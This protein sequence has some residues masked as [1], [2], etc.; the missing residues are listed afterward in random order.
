MFGFLK[1]ELSPKPLDEVTGCHVSGWGVHINPSTCVRYH[2]D[3]AYQ[4]FLC[5]KL[6]LPWIEKLILRPNLWYQLPNLWW[7]LFMA[8]NLF[9]GIPSNVLLDGNQ[10]PDDDAAGHE[11]LLAAVVDVIHELGLDVLCGGR[12]SPVMIRSLPTTNVFYVMNILHAVY[13]PVPLPTQPLYQRTLY[14]NGCSSMVSLDAA[15]GAWEGSAVNPTH[16][17]TSS[18]PLDSQVERP[19]GKHEAVSATSASVLGQRVSIHF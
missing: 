16:G 12:A 8:P 3:V 5:L 13:F 15:V 10:L 4:G 19:H 14:Q 17:P 7:K 11:T 6:A 1:Y 2:D 9:E 18:A